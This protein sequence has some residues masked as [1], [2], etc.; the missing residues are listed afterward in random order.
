M[1]T[2]QTEPTEITVFFTCGLHP[3]HEGEEV[4]VEEIVDKV[5]DE[6]IILGYD[7]AVVSASIATKTVRVVQV[8]EMR[9]DYLTLDSA[10]RSAFHAAGVGTPGWYTA[11]ISTSLKAELV[12]T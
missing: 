12:D 11:G 4:P 5:T 2:T 6:L 1:R 10:L 3:E 8:I 9:E 7:N